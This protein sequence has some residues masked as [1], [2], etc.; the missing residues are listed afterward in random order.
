[1]NS[2]FFS[3]STPFHHYAKNLEHSNQVLN[4][5]SIDYE[6]PRAILYSANKNRFCIHPFC[7]DL[8]FNTIQNETINKIFIRF[9]DSHTL[10]NPP[11]EYL[12]DCDKKFVSSENFTSIVIDKKEFP[13]HY[14]KV[15]HPKKTSFTPAQLFEDRLQ[16]L[17]RFIC[18]KFLSAN[19]EYE[20]TARILPFTK[21]FKSIFNP[22][23]SMREN[24]RKELYNYLCG[25]NMKSSIHMELQSYKKSTID[26]RPESL[27]R[28]DIEGNPDFDLMPPV[29]SLPITQARVINI[30]DI[31]KIKD[32]FERV[33]YFTKNHKS[34][35]VE[36]FRFHIEIELFNVKHND[37]KKISVEILNPA[38][39]NEKPVEL[40]ITGLVNKEEGIKGIN[41][42]NIAVIELN[43][44]NY[45][46]TNE[47][48][49]IVPKKTYK[50]DG[51]TFVDVARTKL[52]HLSIRI[53]S[54][55]GEK[56]DF[57]TS[58]ILLLPRDIF[59]GNSGI[60]HFSSDDEKQLFTDFLKS[61][62]M[63]LDPSIHKTPSTLKR[64]IDRQEN[65]EPKRRKI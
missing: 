61:D 3:T 29:P 17:T 57:C 48:A 4:I 37:I 65:N 44:A 56:C 9:Y 36:L 33:I 8:S 31:R 23:P 50:L 19:F 49:K 64:R 7:I 40:K 51:M 35:L 43:T 30:C 5:Q 20:H 2:N 58:N 24:E 53:E 1:M 39:K 47:I 10:S 60:K 11:L 41:K 27:T 32:Q 25:E 62:F 13:V 38:N 15:M 46:Y 28:L 16:S 21:N 12:I 6:L 52:R 45:P 34:T 22:A 42:K 55:S 54:K 63:T 59:S 14:Q 26:N 18:I